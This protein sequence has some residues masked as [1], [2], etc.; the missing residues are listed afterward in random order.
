MSS[1]QKCSATTADGTPC[2]M[3]EETPGLGLCRFHNPANA[4]KWKAARI[5]GGKARSFKS[6]ILTD[7]ENM[8]CEPEDILNIVTVAMHLVIDRRMVPGAAQAIAS[9]GS[10]ALK[11][12]EVIN[13][14]RRIEELER[15]L[16]E[17]DVI[18]V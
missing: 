5:R 13:I 15:R 8:A 18:N 1:F 4:D 11:A 9:L 17:K 6:P 12:H 10:T 3:T 7:L 14:Q 16:E 2:K